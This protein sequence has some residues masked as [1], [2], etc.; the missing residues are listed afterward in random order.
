M[1]WFISLRAPG[2]TERL[3]SLLFRARCRNLWTTCLRPSSA[4]H[5]VGA[6]CPSPSNTCLTSWMSKLISIRSMI[7]MSGTP[8]RVTG[9]EEGRWDGAGWRLT[10]SQLMILPTPPP[11]SRNMSLEIIQNKRGPYL[12]ISGVGKSLACLPAAEKIPGMQNAPSAL[13]SPNPGHRA[14]SDGWSGLRTMVAGSWLLGL[15]HPPGSSGDASPVL[16]L[17]VLK[18]FPPPSNGSAEPVLTKSA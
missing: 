5:I 16:I 8:G 6:P 18:V 15:L 1:T 7:T 4:Q 11:A 3:F 12:C 2:V 14:P 9:N 17:P 13:P 10:I